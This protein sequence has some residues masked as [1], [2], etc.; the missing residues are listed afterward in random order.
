[1]AS[2]THY[3][4][5]ARKA[6]LDNSLNLTNS[7]TLVIY[8][9]TQP[10]NADTALSGNT[11]LATFTLANPAWG[12][13]TG[14]GSATVTKTLNLPANVTASATG[15]ATFF[16]VF[17]S[18]GVTAVVDGSAGTSSADCILNTT[19]FNTGDAVSITSCVYSLTA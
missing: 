9:G 7:G 8:S 10:T 4:N 13:A 6:C 19:S 2:N 18:D 1:M 5:A 3:G 16:R 15:T 14:T 12:A 11:A 17:E